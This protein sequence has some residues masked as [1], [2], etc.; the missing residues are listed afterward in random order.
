[1]SQPAELSFANGVGERSLVDLVEHHLVA[2]LAES[3]EA[4]Y[5]AIAVVTERVDLVFEFASQP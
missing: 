3:R 2:D 1:M 4:E 5:C